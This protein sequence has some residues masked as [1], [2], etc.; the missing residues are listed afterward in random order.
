MR[1]DSEV[2]RLQANDEINYGISRTALADGV[3]VIDALVSLYALLPSLIE[4]PANG[5]SPDEEDSHRVALTLYGA[6]RYQLGMSVLS[7]FHGR[8]TDGMVFLR[9]AVELCAFAALVRRHHHRAG[10]WLEASES[11][12]AYRKYQEK[13]ATRKLFLAS[14]PNLADLY[15]RYDLCSKM[16]HSSVHTVL[17]HVRA[18]GDQAH[19]SYGDIDATDDPRL[20]ACVC[21]VIETHQ[22]I[23]A[24]FAR[25][26]E[27]QLQTH[28][29][30]W[31]E[32]FQAVEN[33]VAALRASWKPM[34][35]S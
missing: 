2:D 29:R 27:R 19:F 3:E 25:S 4:S 30:E 35:E 1:E 8:A 34:M 9:R 16:M 10:I 21:Y 32:A 13:F 24:I 28:E 17:K 26:F 22:K 23:Q 18:I 7:I 11:K 6:C 14:D 33:K 20:K 15:E 5:A 12:I 31:A